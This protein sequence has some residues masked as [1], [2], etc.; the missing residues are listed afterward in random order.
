MP[1]ALERV[2]GLA[3][4]IRIQDQ[5]AQALRKKRYEHGALTLETIQ[6]KP[7]FDGDEVVELKIEQRNRTKELIE[8]FMIAVNS[9]T[10]RFLNAKKFPSIRRVV[11]IPK[12]W[13]RI[14]D[15]AAQ[16]NFEL[17]KK[18]DSIALNEFLMKEKE[19]DAARF[20]DLSL[21]IIKLL[22]SGEYLAEKPGRRAPG[23]F[24]LSVKEYTHSTAPNRRYPDL[25]TQRLLKAA[26][27]EEPAPYS[28]ENLEKLAKHI[29]DQEDIATKVERKT[30][31]AA[32]AL[33]LEN[34]IGEVF[35]GFVTGASP[36]GYWVRIIELPVE[37]KLVSGTSGLDVGDSIQVELSGVDVERGY[38]DFKRLKK[39]RR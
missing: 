11:Q 2:A 38:I 6:S 30:G 10:A 21:T 4:N 36:K 19:D 7:I 15:V 32:A 37:G 27:K 17:P 12:R 31:K 35:N 26:L 39:V 8:D 20:P 24:S 3:E 18:P 9:V 22:G 13:D 34:R 33:V 29:T 23:H 25:V 5:A 1:A 28:F 16:Y 14:V